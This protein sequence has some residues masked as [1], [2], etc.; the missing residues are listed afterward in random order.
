MSDVP[1]DNK[2]WNDEEWPKFMLAHDAE[3][4]D[5][6]PLNECVIHLHRPRFVGKVHHADDG[7]IGIE[8]TFIDDPDLDAIDVAR[9]M[10]QTGEFYQSL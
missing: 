8:P 4:V 2:I 6:I 1:K 9:L 10:R 7:S 3:S 5:S